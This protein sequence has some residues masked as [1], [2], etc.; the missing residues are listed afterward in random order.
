MRIVIVL[1]IAGILLSLVLAWV[2]EFAW[3]ADHYS[4]RRERAAVKRLM[5]AL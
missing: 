5:D 2:I 4:L 1:G 3:K